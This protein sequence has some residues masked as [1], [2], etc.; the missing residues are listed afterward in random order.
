MR[1]PC[2]LKPKKYPRQSQT[3]LWL[4]I[5][6]PQLPLLQQVTKFLLSLVVGL[7]MGKITRI[8]T[9]LSSAELS[10]WNWDWPQ[11]KSCIALINDCYFS[12]K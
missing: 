2:P 3:T 12:Q 10:N 8:K 6:I 11:P 4:P 9:E 5:D 1:Y 7:G